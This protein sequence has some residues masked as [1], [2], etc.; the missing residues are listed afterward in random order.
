[1][2]LLLGWGSVDP[3]MS[4]YNFAGDDSVIFPKGYIESIG[5]NV[6]ASGS[7][8]L[9]NG[10]FFRTDTHDLSQTNSSWANDANLL[11]FDYPISEASDITP[12]LNLTTNTSNCG[13]SPILN[14]TLLNATANDNAEPYQSYT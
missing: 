9:T 13:I 7:G 4:G 6:T 12:L 14:A 8:Q 5:A 1:M 10:C 2:R 3:Q 11:G